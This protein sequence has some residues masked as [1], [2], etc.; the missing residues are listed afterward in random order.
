ADHLVFFLAELFP[1]RTNRAAHADDPFRAQRVS[2]P[3]GLGG[4]VQVENDLS[5]TFA[6]PQVDEHEVTMVASIRDPTEQH[7]FAA[8]IAGAERAAVVSSFEFVDETGHG[9]AVIA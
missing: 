8:D 1:A 6:V 5:H 9:A 4:G 3:M 2:D 7:H